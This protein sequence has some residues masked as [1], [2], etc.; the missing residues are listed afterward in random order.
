MKLR[1]QHKD[2]TI[3][4]IRLGGSINVSEGKTLDHLVDGGV[5]HYFTKDGF[6]DGW[7][8]SESPEDADKIIR[9]AERRREFDGADSQ[10]LS[11]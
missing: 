11:N 10:D 9:R 3:E 8:S 7:S 2:G 1:V 5:E 4:T 6:Y